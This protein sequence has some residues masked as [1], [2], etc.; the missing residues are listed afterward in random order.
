MLIGDLNAEPT[1]ATICDFCEIYNI[2]HLIK[3][4]KCFKNSTKPICIDLIVRNRSSCFQDT[5]FVETGLSDI[6]K[7]SVKVT[8]M[9]YTKQKPSIAHYRKLKNFCNNSFI[10]DIELLLSK[11]CNQQ[12]VPFKILKESVNITLGK[13]APLNKRYVRANQSPFMNKKLSKK[14]MKRSRLRNKL[15]NT[16]S[17]IDRK[18]YNKQRNDVA[19]LLRSDKKN[20]YS[21]L[22]TKVVTDH[23]TLWKT[24]KPLL[25]EKVTKHS[26]IKLVEDDKIISRDDQIAKSFS[27][28][29]VNIPFLDMQ[30]N[31][32]K[33]PD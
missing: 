25:S 8:K 9:Y 22:D 14:M 26:K 6:H 29:F 19:S 15:L 32:Y 16:K 23:R 4:K 7:M 17:G 33:H 20:F 13:N 10:K 18:D 31:A 24:V 11:L 12:N 5:V 1:E 2:K 28:Y 27:E 3:D 30:S 21:N